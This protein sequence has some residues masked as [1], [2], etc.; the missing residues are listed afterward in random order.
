MPNDSKTK[1]RKEAKRIAKIAGNQFKKA[2]G[3][4]IIGAGNSV[5][6]GTQKYANFVEK[7][8]APRRAKMESEA[9]A[10]KAAKRKAA[11]KPGTLFGIPMVREVPKKMFDIK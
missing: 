4:A 7:S 2:V 6:K 9:A 10:K 5:A 3:N 11:K 8:G 1:A